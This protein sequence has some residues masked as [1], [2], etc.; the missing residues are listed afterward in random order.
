M[1][2]LLYAGDT[3]LLASQRVALIGYLQPYLRHG[4]PTGCNF[5]GEVPIWTRHSAKDGYD[6]LKQDCLERRTGAQRVGALAGISVSD[7]S[8]IGMGMKAFLLRPTETNRLF[9]ALVVPWA[10]CGLHAAW[11]NN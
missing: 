8:G 10:M 7:M 4:Q 3:L 1:V 6:V 5:I 11:L 2:D 9:N